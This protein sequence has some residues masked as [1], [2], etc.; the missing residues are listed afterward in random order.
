MNDPM[1]RGTIHQVFMYDQF[2]NDE[3]INIMLNYTKSC[4]QE[5]LILDNIYKILK[6]KL[7]NI[8][9]NWT[10]TAVGNVLYNETTNERII[11]SSISDD[12]YNPSSQYIIRIAYFN[13][14]VMSK[15][16]NEY[17]I[18]DIPD[19]DKIIEELKPYIIL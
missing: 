9:P 8:N 18:N 14:D 12:L 7:K 19:I 4:Y 3:E 6:N 2:L 13:T 10:L 5:D 17:K 1:F 15:Y 16:I 11:L